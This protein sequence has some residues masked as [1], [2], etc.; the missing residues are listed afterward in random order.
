MNTLINVATGVIRSDDI[1]VDSA[2][3]IR[4]K[5]TSGLDDKKLREIFLKRED[6]AKTFATIRKTIKVGETMV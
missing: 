1:N 3:D 6:Q 5:I 4:M 2:V